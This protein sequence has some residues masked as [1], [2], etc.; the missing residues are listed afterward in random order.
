MSRLR[1][2]AIINH[3]QSTSATRLWQ[4]MTRRKEPKLA[5]TPR[6]KVW[7][8]VDGTYVFGLGIC[9]I[10]EAIEETG[11]IKKAATSVGKSYRHVWARIKEVEQTLGISLVATT[12]GGSDARRSTLT[13]PAK[14]LTVLYRDLREQVFH[15]AEEQFSTA[16][17]KVVNDAANSS[18]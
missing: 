6:A 7:L 16:I 4:P 2:Q 8:E 13:E 5:I 15:F 18:D 14:Q 1:S 12:V 10:L 9:R 3:H 11:S 17:Q